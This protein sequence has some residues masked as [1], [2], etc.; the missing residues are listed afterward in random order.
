MEVYRVEQEV[1]RLIIFL[2]HFGKSEN[3]LATVPKAA[4]N[5]QTG[6]GSSQATSADALRPEKRLEIQTYHKRDG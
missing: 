4:D 2:K 5:H 1:E 6:T 3:G